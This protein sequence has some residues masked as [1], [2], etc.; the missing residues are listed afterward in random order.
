MGAALLVELLRMWTN[1]KAMTKCLGLFVLDLDRQCSYRKNDA[2]LQDLAT[3]HFHDLVCM[4]AVFWMLSVC[5]RRAFS[6]VFA[7]LFS[8]LGFLS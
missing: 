1:Y 8:H 6:F 2:P 5:S 3:F 4:F 7:H